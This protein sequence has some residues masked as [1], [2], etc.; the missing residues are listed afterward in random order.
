MDSSE[1]EHVMGFDVSRTWATKVSVHQSGSLA[2]LIFREA[3]RVT[4][5]DEDGKQTSE[6]VERNVASVLMTQENATIFGKI[7][8]ENFPVEADEDTG[9]GD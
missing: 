4:I 6:E 7:L 2:L 9:D 3:A 8:S 1:A 5:E